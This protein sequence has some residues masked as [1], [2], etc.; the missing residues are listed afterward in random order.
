MS[1]FNLICI[2]LITKVPFLCIF[3][4]VIPHLWEI[5]NHYYHGEYS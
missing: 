4:L 3:A 5:D 1:L 2:S